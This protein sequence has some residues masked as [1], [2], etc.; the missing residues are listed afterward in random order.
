MS[1]SDTFEADLLK[2]IFQNV[3]ITLLGDAAGILGSAAAGSIFVSLHTADP[4][5]AGTQATSEIGYTGYAR[6][7]VARG[8]GQWAVSGTAPTKVSPVS[9][10]NFPAG[11]AGSGT[12]THVGFGCSTSGAGK[13]L[14]KGIL[15]VPIVCGAGVTPILGTASQITED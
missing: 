8:A 12:A 13:L 5:E 3:P 7:A 4:G 10:V 1:K 15:D 2:L 14:Y 11:I 6:V 9:A